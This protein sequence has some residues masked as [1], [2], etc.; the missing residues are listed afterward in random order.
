MLIVSPSFKLKSF[1]SASGSCNVWTTLLLAPTFGA[2]S[3]PLCLLISCRHTPKSNAAPRS[4]NPIPRYALRLPSTTLTAKKREE[5]RTCSTQTALV[6][7]QFA[8]SSPESGASRRTSVVTLRSSSSSCSSCSFPPSPP[9]PLNCCVRKGRIVVV[10]IT[11]N[12][13]VKMRDDSR[14]TPQSEALYPPEMDLGGE[15]G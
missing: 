13:A 9:G 6:Y 8:N 10:S 1:F 14:S 15:M 2:A 12:R 4:S 7:G 3:S 5:S 11:L